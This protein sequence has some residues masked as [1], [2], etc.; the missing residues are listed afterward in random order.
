MST[1]LAIDA[2]RCPVCGAANQC[3]MEMQ[4]ATGVEQPP[5]WCTQV[6]FSRE[7]LRGLPVAARGLAC[8]CARCAT[9]AE[10]AR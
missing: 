4:K 2:S 7:L 9:Q 3:A 10:P 6:D 1:A 5:C 8:I